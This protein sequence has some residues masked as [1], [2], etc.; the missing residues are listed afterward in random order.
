MPATTWGLLLLVS[1]IGLA[2]AARARRS[3]GLALAAGGVLL[4]F[5]AYA[6]LLLLGREGM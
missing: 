3:R 2:V 4:A 1:A 5:L 6:G